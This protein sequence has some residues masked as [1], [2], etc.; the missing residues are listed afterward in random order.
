MAMRI[1]NVLEAARVSSS[2]EV[3]CVVGGVGTGKTQT[4]ITRVESLLKSGVSQDDILV[5]TATAD[6]ARFFASR[7][8]ERLASEGLD[9]EIRISSVRGFALGVLASDDA[10]AFTGREPRLLAP[11]EENVLMEDIKTTGVRPGRLKEMLK[12]LYRG[13]SELADDDSD[14]LITGEE[15]LVAAAVKDSLGLVHA[16]IEPEVSNLAVGFLRGCEGARGSI[17]RSYVLVDDFQALSRASQ[18]LAA[19]VASR[20]LVV[21]GDPVATSA[22]YDSF[23]YAKGFDELVSSCGSVER[24]A[25]WR[26]SPA[27]VKALDELLEDDCFSKESKTRFEASACNG[28]SPEVREFGFPED[29]LMGVADIVSEA[30]DGG[31]AAEDIFIAVPSGAWRKNV[32]KALACKGISSETMVDSCSLGKDIRSFDKSATARIFTALALVADPG[33]ALAWRSWCGFGDYLAASSVFSAVRDAR[34]DLGI[35]VRDALEAIAMESHLLDAYVDDNVYGIEHVREAFFVGNR[36]IEEASGVAGWSLLEAL[37]TMIL[38]FDCKG[39]PSAVVN[40]CGSVKT[41]DTASEIYARAVARL[42]L[43]SFGDGEGSVRVGGYENACGLNPKMIVLTGFVNGLFPV[44]AYFDAT[45]TSIDR[46]ARMHADDA[47]LFYGILG[48]SCDRVVVTYFSKA[49]LE[50]ADFLSLKIER[51]HVEGGERICTVSPSEYIKYLK[52]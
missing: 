12:F 22:V 9:A 35:E 6:A 10:R 36:L 28:E 3:N 19:T 5:L 30:I 23:P 2:L 20:C 49:S 33:N 11:F 18:V 27:A 41:G 17:S 7:L 43:P 14:W 51:L 15:E 8:A 44:G 32:V 26:R 31:M 24:L 25:S 29:E 37:S 52:D 45:K 16:M 48:K 42:N 21:A 34:R 13:W 39:V 38:G 4:L 47:R 1:G 50:E 40:L 46:R